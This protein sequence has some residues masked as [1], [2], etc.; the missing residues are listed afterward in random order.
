MDMYP[1]AG[2]P[3]NESSQIKSVVESQAECM[4]EECR[5]VTDS[6]RKKV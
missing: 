3:S 4:Q 1:E 6:F 2:F 5:G